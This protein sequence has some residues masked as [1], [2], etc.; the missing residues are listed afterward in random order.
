[1]G[2]GL[3]SSRAGA[4]ALAEGI[5]GITEVDEGYEDIVNSLYELIQNNE[6]QIIKLAEM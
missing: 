1:V 5:Y 2:E 4:E 6:T 3:F